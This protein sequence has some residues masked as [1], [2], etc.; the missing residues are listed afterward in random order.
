[1]LVRERPPLRLAVDVATP[2]GGHYRWARDEPGAANV[3][4]S[5]VFSDTMPGGFEQASADLARLVSQQYPD[6]TDLSTVTIYGPGGDVAWQGRLE[7]SPRQ[8]GQQSAVSPQLTGW[9]AHLDD[10]TSCRFLGLD[11]NLSNWQGAS[12]Q[13]QINLLNNNIDE[14]DAS[15]APDQTSGQPAL[16]TQITGPWSR[17]SQSEGWYDAKGIPI[18]KLY[19]AWKLGATVGYTDTNWDWQVALLTDDWSGSGDGSGN[20]RAAGPAT[21]EMS[22]AAANRIFAAVTSAYITGPAGA[23]GMNYPIFWTYLGVVSNHGLPIQGTLTATGGIGLLASD[24]IAHLLS[25]YA[26]LLNYTTGANGTIRPSTYSIPQAAWTDLT[27]SSVILKAVTAYE[28]QDWAVWN[29]ARIS[30]RPVFYWAP[31]G[32]FG[33]NWRARVGDIQLQET[34]PQADRIYNGAVVT[35]TDVSGITRTVG[36]PGSGC[37]VE[38]SRLLDTDPANPANQIQ[39]PAGTLRHWSPPIQMGTGTSDAAIQIGQVFLQEQKLLDTSG[40]ATVVGHVQD[41]HGVWWPA[42]K[43]RSGD[44]LTVVDAHDTSPRRIIRK[45]YDDTQKAASISLDS[46]PDGLQALLS[47]LG[48]SLSAIGF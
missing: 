36:P 17:Y 42:W 38:D 47:R 41:D 4:G 39:T 32:T 12:V 20:L 25:Q 26:P 24:I 1:M 44:T 34:G 30:D 28:L 40:Q 3:P 23:N 7:K 48:V 43:M 11:C 46:P 45:S 29:G 15:S 27:T 10:D 37:N 5:M 9:Q 2:D 33:R 18:G 19:Y 31:R 14:T 6:L 16:T 13:R 8:W 35:F 22:A 21:G